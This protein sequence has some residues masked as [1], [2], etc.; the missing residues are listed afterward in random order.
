MK[1]FFVFILLFTSLCLLQA[2]KFLDGIFEDNNIMVCFSISAIG[3]I[4]GKIDVTY[5]ND[6]IKTN[7]NSFN[8]F[9]EEFEVI[10][11][12][13]DC[14]DL[15]HKEWND[16]GSYIQAIYK[17]TIRN[18]KV[19]EQALNSIR[20][21]E[22]VLWADFVTINR[23]KYTPNDS[24]YD[25]LWY[26]PQTETDRVWD[27]VRDASDVLIGI[28]DSGIKWNHPDLKNNIWLNEDEMNG[29]TINWD[30]GTFTGDG[31]DNDGNGK[32]DDVMGWDF[33]N[34]DN[35]PLQNWNYN[36]HGSHVAGCASAV[37]DNNLGTVGPGFNAKLLNMQGA[38]DNQDSNGNPHGYQQMV[39]AA[40]MGA[41]I[42]NASWGGQTYNLSYANT[43]VNYATNFGSLVVVAAG[44]GNVE[45]N[46]SYMD[47]PSDC[48]NALN[49]AA[50]DRN[51][52]KASF[53]EY[54]EPIDISAPGTEI[55]STIIED[56]G[57]EN[58]QGTSMAS[59]IVCG[60]AALVKAVNPTFTPAQLRARIEA[61]ADYIDDINP[62]FEGKM[63]AGRINAFTAVLYDKLAN[64]KITDTILSEV[65]GDGDG[66]VNPGETISLTIN[67]ANYLDM[68]T[69]LNWA[70][71]YDT[72]IYLRC[73]QR[74][75]VIQDSTANIGTVVAGESVWNNESPFIFSTASNIP[76]TP[77]KFRL[78]IESNLNSE[79]PYSLEI[80]FE[81]SVSLNYPNWTFPLTGQSLSSP[82]I[83]DLNNDDS[84]EI[85]FGDLEG[86]VNALTYQGNQLPGFPVNVNA[87]VILPL[88]I[89]D[90]NNDQLEEI[91]AVTNNKEAYAI[92]SNGSILWGPISLDN[93]LVKA[94]P[95]VTD[96]D[97][98]G[99]KEAI[100][101]TLN[102][103]LHIINGNGEELTN[104]PCDFPGN[105]VFNIATA[106]MNLNG[107]QEVI[108][109]TISGNI[110]AIDYL[111]QSNISGF[112]YS[113]GFNTESAPI[114]TNID[115]DQYP[116][117]V[118]AI[119]SQG[120]IKI[121]NHD[122]STAYDLTPGGTIKQDILFADFDN[123]GAKE[124]LFTTYDGFVHALSLNGEE[125]TNFPLDIGSYIEGYPLLS[126]LDNEGLCLMFGD[127]SGKLHAINH[128]ASEAGNFPIH[129][130]DNLKVSPALG[131]ID[132]DG[133]LDLIISTITEMRL[134]DLKRIGYSNWIMHRGNPGRTANSFEATTPNDEQ[135]ASISPTALQGNYP[136]P[137][138]P[139]TTIHF[140]LD[141]QSPV[142]IDIY[143]LKGQKVKTLVDETLSSG[144]HTI[145]WNG[146]DNSNKQVSSGVYLY[147]MKNGIFTK[148]KKMILLK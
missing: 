34:N 91:V 26:I 141:K 72:N 12:N 43:Y 67:L 107:Q 97:G 86:N 28:S 24:L 57:Y 41:D 59:P 87:Q 66:V 11:I 38:P 117:I 104:Y 32:I 49:V 27:F 132:E 69:G 14:P 110:L 102:G 120:I 13:Q 55:R 127:T 119:S 138:N 1:K 48:P 10:A 145:V 68:S 4:D 148:S 76:T 3:N 146:K 74:G 44:N 52:L 85:I 70:T 56:N 134:L 18:N 82:A 7:I 8:N 113:L 20:K 30:N 83:T 124:L 133:D 16:N 9:A 137:F 121:I 64:F 50:T 114:I 144:K 71:S 93:Q 115:N 136:N 15:K 95:I 80:P 54:G 39:Y 98:D 53:S 29:V 88:A 108:L 78:Y 143:N 89:G 101:C 36:Y 25:Y 140:S 123:D 23:L 47:A 17:I 60:I 128:N 42:I 73:N 84:K 118:S 116:E 65:N 19:I 147:R 37:G 75:V 45:H 81:R 31:I 46:A 61:T 122:G 105:F 22:D 35:N 77:I 99:T 109:Q 103:K 58:A 142:K 130:N 126:N 21:C 79:F 100:I 131:D 111:T 94:N 33:V 5:N 96:I 139:E 90:L 6:I 2:D 51:D 92:S 63:G 135:I 112:P 62:A 40:D 106:D 129:L 125:L